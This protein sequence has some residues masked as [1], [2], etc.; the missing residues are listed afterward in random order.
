MNKYEYLH[1][2]QGHYGFLYG[3]EDV[4]CSDIR[5]EAKDALKSH[6][7]NE[8]Y[9]FRIIERRVLNNQGEVK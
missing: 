6:R 8:S 4:F 9:A 2:V 1:I 3:W 7:E 5:K